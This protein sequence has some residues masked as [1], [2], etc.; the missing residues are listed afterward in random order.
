[1]FN[2]T[3]SEQETWNTCV[4]T[5]LG[6]LEDSLFN[7]VV[8]STKI[9]FLASNEYLKKNAST[10]TLS[11][12][13]SPSSYTM[14]RKRSFTDS[15]QDRKQQKLSSNLANDIA[16]SLSVSIEDD[17][18]MSSQPINVYCKPI[19]QEN[20]VP[21]LRR[22]S[23]SGTMNHSSS[24]LSQWLEKQA[25]INHMSVP[26][27]KS[28]FHEKQKLLRQHLELLQVP[29]QPFDSIREHLSKVLRL[30]D[31]LS[32]D[33]TISFSEIFPEWTL[34]ES[35]INKL[36]TYVQSIEDMSFSISNMIPQTNDLLQDIK[37]LQTTLDSKMALYGDALLQNGLEWRAM[38]MPVDDQLI[39]ATKQ[40]IHNLC[41]GVLDALDK[42]CKKAQQQAQNIQDLIQLP[43][44]EKLMASI[45][46]GLEF[47]S[48][49]ST[50]IGFTS[51]KLVY[52]CRILATIYGQWVSENLERI[53]DKPRDKKNAP[54]RIDIRY[55][56]L[57]DNM[58]R[59]IS[60]LYTLSELDMRY[61]DISHLSR[62]SIESLSAILVEV[63][64]RA[65]GIIEMERKNAS[66]SINSKIAG[67][68]MTN[69]QTT[70]IYM[71]ESL[72]NFANKV[73]ELAGREWADG[74]RIKALYTYLKDLENS[75]E[76]S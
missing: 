22:I 8:P 2:G 32:G 48:E 16:R 46:T 1:M 20:P 10:E 27:F 23:L 44:G 49:A 61:R 40:W 26:E 50:F 62:V 37:G 38:G 47:I 4:K 69:P 5:I 9:D 65:V 75:L 18:D 36:A 11:T 15:A 29:N 12:P 7:G 31:D 60:S 55:M 53:Q 70:F 58:T 45:L 17:V 57:M 51:Q 21:T 63:A 30:A 67:N 14:K 54:K 35:R 28:L 34:Y 25:Q 6:L 74:G 76:S 19:D 56:Q 39:N 42:E 33:H 13:Q 73:I 52:D 24:S 64:L 66:V 68:I 43:I 41:V 59:I 3:R 71:G 72:L